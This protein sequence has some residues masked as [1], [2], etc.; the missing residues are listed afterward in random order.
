MRRTDDLPV[1]LLGFIAI[2]VV[3]PIWLQYRSGFTAATPSGAF[4]ASM[5]LPAVVALYVSSWVSPELAGVVLGGFLVAGI[6]LLVPWLYE[7]AD[8]LTGALVEDPLAR[9]LVQLALPVVILTFLY[10]L[11]RRRLRE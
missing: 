6:V 5:I 11:G 1:A 4:L 9:T 3:A 2:V 10:Q 8:M 7:F